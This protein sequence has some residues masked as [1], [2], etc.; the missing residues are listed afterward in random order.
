[1]DTIKTE[2]INLEIPIKLQFSSKHIQEISKL[3][4]PEQDLTLEKDQAKIELLIDGINKILNKELKALDSGN[5]ED[6]SSQLIS[7]NV[8]YYTSKYYKKQKYQN[9][10]NQ[11]L[12]D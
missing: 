6:K 3:I 2:I 1:M 7:D 10:V 8:L 12:Y 4:Y 5:I 9:E 11:I